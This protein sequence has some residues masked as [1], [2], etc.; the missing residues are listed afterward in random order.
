ADRALVE[1]VRAGAAGGEP[2]RIRGHSG[3]AHEPAAEIAGDVVPD[4]AGVRPA[5]VGREPGEVRVE[6]VQRGGLVLVGH[7]A[8]A[9]VG[10]A[11]AAAARHD[12][13]EDVRQGGALG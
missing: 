7:A 6:L 11:A 13:A 3:G 1:A 4:V 5:R 8:Q 2:L 10:R 9:L 12:V